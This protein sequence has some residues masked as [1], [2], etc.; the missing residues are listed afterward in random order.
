M[1]P[2]LDLHGVS[3]PR[4]DFQGGVMPEPHPI[5]LAEPPPLLHEGGDVG[6][7][8][9]EPTRPSADGN[10]TVSLKGQNHP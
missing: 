2:G 7:S 5:P 8:L 1:S 9:L 10:G 6:V 4:L 3:S